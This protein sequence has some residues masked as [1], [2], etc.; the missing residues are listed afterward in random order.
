MIWAP[1]R[2]KPLSRYAR[3]VEIATWGYLAFACL[4]TIVLWGLGDRW[5]PATILLFI[6][7]WIFLL[8]LVVL[9]PAVVVFR[10]AFL[11]PLALA[12]AIILGPVMGFRTG[13]HRWLPAPTGA[14]VRVVTFNADDGDRLAP[15]LPTI[16]SEWDADLVAIEE[17]GEQLTAATTRL[18][19][20]YHHEHN[21]ICTMSRYPILSANIMDRSAFEAV[22][23]N[24]AAGIGGSA[25]VI[26]YELQTPQGPMTLAVLHLETPRK[27]LEGL[28]E[29][30]RTFNL[31]RL[32]L[33]TELREI[34]STAARA[35][36]NQ[37]RVPTLVMGDF[38]TPVESRIFQS[39]WGDL[40]D[41]FSYAGTGLGM[42]KYNGWIRVRID[43]ILM[44]D[45]WH[46]DRVRIGR[47]LG[48][49]HMPVIADLTLVEYK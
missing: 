6:G 38:N 47:D 31:K 13:W 8:P 24:D 15:Q 5:W 26:R 10:R 29:G 30:V 17:C 34:E 28:A 35:W 48:S 4:L 37:G 32:Q 20:W 22:K 11:V 39:H 33:N 36:V 46:T 21:G 49:D 2:K 27:G 41:A 16:L 14:S 42:S 3:P 43:H 19:G 23:E 45:N 18:T 9:L 1:R 7:R 44:S 40:T 25:D 12:T